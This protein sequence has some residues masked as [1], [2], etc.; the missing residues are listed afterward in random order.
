MTF[1][2]IKHTND[3]NQTFQIDASN[4]QGDFIK[5]AYACNEMIQ[6][7]NMLNFKG[8]EQNVTDLQQSTS[9][10]S[11]V[12]NKMSLQESEKVKEKLTNQ[13]EK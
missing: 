5:V 7:S 9:V 10:L 12:G 8:C 6:D 2:M 3:L 1:L 11:S 13:F 4:E